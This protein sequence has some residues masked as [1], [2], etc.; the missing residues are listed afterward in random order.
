MSGSPTLHEPG[1]P[2]GS[3]PFWEAG[4]RGELVLPWCND[5]GAAFWYP[6]PVCPRCLGDDLDWRAAAGTAEVHAV[7]VQHRPGMGRDEA[8]GPYTVAVVE[9]PEGVRM[10]TN[11]VGCDP[12]DVTVGMAVTVTWHELSDGRALPMFAPPDG[13]SD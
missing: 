1:I 4:K 2:E 3:E 7:S 9:L 11:V 8:D 6:R 13:R 5:C 12:Y 10:L